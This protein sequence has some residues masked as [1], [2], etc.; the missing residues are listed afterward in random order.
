MIEAKGRYDWEHT[1]GLMAL[2]V[3][4]LRDPKK[5]RPAKATDFNPYYSAPKPVLRGDDQ[6]KLKDVFVCESN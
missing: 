3:N 2:I 6:Q 1:S 4:L 5:S